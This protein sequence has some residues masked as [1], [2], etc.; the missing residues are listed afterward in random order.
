MT[1]V[2]PPEYS[3]IFLEPDE[4]E[5]QEI[6]PPL[7]KLIGLI[8][9]LPWLRTYG[10]CAGSAYHGQDL[11]EEQRFFLG[12]FVEG[13]KNGINRLQSWLEE[14]N[15]LNGPTGLRAEVESVHKHPFGQGSVDGW[16][17]YRITTHV[18]RGRTYSSLSQAHLRMIKSLETALEKLWPT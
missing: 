18:I 10:C 2:E 8:N 12:L 15:R 5:Y 6:D 17:A 9:S 13:E 11:G 4:I 7:R 1:K 16:Y 3:G 14:A